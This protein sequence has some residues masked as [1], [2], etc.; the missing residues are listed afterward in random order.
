MIK[1]IKTEKFQGLALLVP[2]GSHNFSTAVDSTGKYLQ[3]FIGQYD[4]DG[5]DLGGE[6]KLTENPYLKLKILG[7]ATELTEE[8]CMLIVPEN[9]NGYREECYPDFTPS[10]NDLSCAYVNAKLSF[11]SL[12]QSLGCYSLNPVNK[13]NPCGNGVDFI[14]YDP[15]WVKEYDTAQA[16]TGTW[17]ILQKLIDMENSAFMN[18]FKQLVLEA[19]ERGWYPD[20]EDPEYYRAYYNDGLTPDQAIDEELCDEDY[21]LDD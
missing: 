3:F 4:D 19:A 7:K 2:D 8:Q 1:E 13:P 10:T 6:L 14:E 12:M 15:V 18:W 11:A 9:L 20:T 21:D 17:L 16:N 5:D